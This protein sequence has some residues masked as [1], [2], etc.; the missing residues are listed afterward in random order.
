MFIVRTSE[1]RAHPLG[2]L[3][4]R[5]QPVGLDDLALA[6]D[7]LRLHRI[8]PRTFLG[9]KAGQDAYPAPAPFDF[10]VM[11]AYPAAHLMACVPTGVV[12]NQD[13]NPL[14]E[15]FKLSAAHSRK[16]VVME[17]TGRP[18]TKRTHVL[19]SSGI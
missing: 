5:Q 15:R 3:V 18:S 1:G 10:P 9:Q 4:G 14:A 17:L 6:V 7:P 12:P 16:R 19:S 8:E 11:G 2:Q 13:Q